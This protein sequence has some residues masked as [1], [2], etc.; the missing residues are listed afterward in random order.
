MYAALSVRTL[1]CLFS[2]SYALALSELMVEHLVEELL[3]G[4]VRLL[5]DVVEEGHG[6]GGDGA[7]GGQGEEEVAEPLR[8]A[9]GGG[10]RLLERAL[11]PLHAVVVARSRRA[12]RR[13]GEKKNEANLT[14]SVIDAVAA[15]PREGAR[16]GRATPTPRHPLSFRPPARA[17]ENRSRSAALHIDVMESARERYAGAGARGA[18]F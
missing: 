16:A 10:E 3:H 1:L 14:F 8:A 9:L 11:D 13:K 7:E 18:K 15:S 12:W 6:L 2:T 5:P 17:L 4:D